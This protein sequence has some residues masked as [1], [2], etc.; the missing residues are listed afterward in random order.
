MG[1]SFPP[2]RGRWRRQDEGWQRLESHGSGRW[3]WAAHWLACRQCATPRT[4]AGRT[5]FADDLGSAHGGQRADETGGARTLRSRRQAPVDLVETLLVGGV[6]A[7]EAGGANS[8][9]AL[10]RVDDQARILRDDQ[11]RRV[12]ERLR[13]SSS[14]VQCLQAGVFR[15]RRA[16]LFRLIDRRQIR[17][18]EQFDG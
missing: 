4:D 5:H 12:V 1:V 17:K 10:E 13:G 16:G 9:F 2:K 8:W 7:Q 6:S 11:Q 3:E 15:E 14:I 18:R